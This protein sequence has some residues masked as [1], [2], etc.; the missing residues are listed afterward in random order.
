MKRKYLTSTLMACICYCSSFAAIVYIDIEDAD[1]ASTPLLSIDFNDDDQTEFTFEGT[2]YDNGMLET[3][4]TFLN[5][6][7]RFATISNDLWDHTTAL[8]ADEMV[9]EDTGWNDYGYAS[10]YDDF[11]T[12]EDAYIAVQFPVEGQQHYGWIRVSWNGNDAFIIKDFAYNDIPETG[13]A[14]G[15]NSTTPGLSIQEIA[16]SPYQVFPNPSQGELHFTENTLLK[17]LRIYNQNGQ[18]LY[19]KKTIP[20]QVD[21]SIL[22]S[23]TYTLHYQDLKGN[24]YRES[25]IK[26]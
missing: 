15:E 2:V 22:A 18:M 7:Y 20:E 14:A 16:N 21:L 6:E 17:E 11:T 12:N 25:F 9:N 26:H 10:I 8:S 5:N 24:L 19:Y 13:I 1:L 3:N 23:G 4:I